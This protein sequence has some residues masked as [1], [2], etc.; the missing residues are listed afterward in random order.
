MAPEAPRVDAMGSPS[1]RFH[2]RKL[3]VYSFGIICYE[4]LSRENP[5]QGVMRTQLR[6]Y[7]EAGNRPQLPDEIPRRLDILINKCWDG[8]PLHR[9]DFAAI[10]TE[11]RF[12]KLGLLSGRKHYG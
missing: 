6:A 2:P 10:C 9:P 4:I 8:N 7:V 3:D 11:L 1:D 5:F 12:I